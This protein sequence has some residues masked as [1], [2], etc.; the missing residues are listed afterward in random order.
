MIIFRGEKASGETT[1]KTHGDDHVHLRLAGA[2]DGG[3]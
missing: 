1:T 2:V 3:N